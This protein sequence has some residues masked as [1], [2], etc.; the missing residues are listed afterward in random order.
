MDLWVLEFHWTQLKYRA[1]FFLFYC[2]SSEGRQEQEPSILRQ[3]KQ[4]ILHSQG[5]QGCVEMLCSDLAD[6]ISSLLLFCQ[7]TSGLTFFCEIL[8]LFS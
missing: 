6:V 7:L 3:L 1:T 4:H 8:G 2:T 5:A